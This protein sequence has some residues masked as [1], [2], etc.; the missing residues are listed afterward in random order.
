MTYGCSSEVG[1][2]KSLLLKHPQEAF[3]DQ[4]NINHQWVDLNYLGCPDFGKAV[5]E[6]NTFVALLQKFVPEIRY[7]PQNDITGLDS[8]YVHDPMI[9]T[10]HGAILCRMG[11]SQ[12]EG[13]PSAAGDFLK[14]LKIPILGSIKEPGKLEGGDVVQFDAQTWSVG[15]GYRTNAEGIRQLRELTKNFIKDLVAVPLPHWNGPA[16]VLHLMSLISPVANNCALVY[17]RLMPVPFREWL[18]ERGFRLI[19]VPDVEYETMACNVLTVAPRKCIMLYGNPQT[20]KLLQDSGI[21]VW[22]YSGEEISKKGG[23]GPTCLTR[24]ICRSG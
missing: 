15:Q 20:K 8:L 23:G 21:E 10:E 22:E 13:E 9:L 4:N 7:L 14:A 16:D 6:Y 11:K 24:P 19:E 12:R 3:I 5:W 1:K 17:S 18:C 2:I